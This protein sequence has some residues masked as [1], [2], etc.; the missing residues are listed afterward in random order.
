MCILLCLGASG[1]VS[2][3]EPW[4]PIP[5]GARLYVA[6]MDWNL[7]AFIASEIQRQ[8][9]PLR[10]VN[11]PEDADFVMTG[12]FQTTGSHM[13]SSGHYIQ[14]R[15]VAADTGKV[16]CTVEAEDYSAPFGRLRAHGPARAAT[17]IVHTLAR[18]VK[19]QAKATPVN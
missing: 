8:A 9:V 10:L 6:Q 11:S 18:R 15:I 14:A 4:S 1:L 7:H 3:K 12:R 17:A 19:S 5:A 16:V 13:I 2:A